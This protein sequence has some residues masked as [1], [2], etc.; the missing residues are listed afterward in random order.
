MNWPEERKKFEQRQN[1]INTYLNSNYDNDVKEFNKYAGAFVISGGMNGTPVPF[2]GPRGPMDADAILLKLYESY[3]RIKK[4][5]KDTA[6]LKDD[7]ANYLLGSSNAE[8]V[9]SK[10]RAIGRLQQE[11]ANLEDISKKADTESVAAKDRQEAI[12]TRN[13]KISFTQMFSGIN[14]PLEKRTYQWLFPVGLALFVVGIFIMWPGISTI[15]TLPALVSASGTNIGLP[16][17]KKPAFVWT[18]LGLMGT[19]VVVTLLAAFGIIHS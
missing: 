19:T 6:D 8:E 18:I 3:A 9:Q 12:K 5:F 14:K 11:I 10:L 15:Y 2:Q 1:A 17:Y 7:I 4:H 16:F 13:E